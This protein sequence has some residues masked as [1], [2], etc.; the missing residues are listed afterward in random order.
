MC[1]YWYCTVERGLLAGTDAQTLVQHLKVVA[2]DASVSCT[3]AATSTIE[4]VDEL[5][6]D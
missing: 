5:G 2:C 3:G 6:V 1:K 4:T